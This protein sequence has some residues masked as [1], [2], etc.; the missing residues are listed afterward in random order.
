MVSGGLKPGATMALAAASMPDSATFSAR[1]LSVV[2]AALFLTARLALERAAQTTD[3]TRA[4]NVAESGME[5]GANAIIAQGFDAGGTGT[6]SGSLAGGGDYSVNW[7]A[8]TALPWF[9]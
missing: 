2:C 8:Q 1:V 3:S 9:T 4:L 6:I 7:D 5:A